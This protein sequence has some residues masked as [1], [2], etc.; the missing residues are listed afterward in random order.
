MNKVRLPEGGRG[1]FQ[2]EL[3]NN[4]LGDCESKVCKVYNVYKVKK[5]ACKFFTFDFR[6]SA[7]DLSFFY[8]EKRRLK[9]LILIL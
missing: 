1:L 4:L 2:I 3:A 8:Q 6:L 9:R 5:F 7:F